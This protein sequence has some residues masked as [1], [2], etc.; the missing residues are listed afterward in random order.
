V[1]DKVVQVIEGIEAPHDVHFSPD[2]RRVYIRNES[3]FVLDVVDQKS[4][5]IIKKIPL[6]GRP[7]TIAVTKDGGRVFVAIREAPGA[8]DVIDTTSLE[9]V[10]SIP[11]K[12]G[13]HDI[14]LTPDGK[15]VVAGSIEGKLLNV[16]DVQ[17]EQPVWEIK[18]DKGV[19]TMAFES[20][21]DGSTRRIFVNTSNI[22][23]FDVVDFTE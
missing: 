18:F 21:R 20:G 17:T 13:L 3:E 12:G 1:T 16:I 4:G 15:Y 23:G 14:Y 8:L 19:R 5:T 9:R 10:K 22:H 7:N 2:G 6:S 11:M